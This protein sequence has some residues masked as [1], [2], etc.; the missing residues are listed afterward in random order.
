MSGIATTGS[1]TATGFCFPIIGG[2][3]VA[4][5]FLTRYYHNVERYIDDWLCLAAWVSFG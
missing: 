4:L 2:I 3:L 1:A 5:R